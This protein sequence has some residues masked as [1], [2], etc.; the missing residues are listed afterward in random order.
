MFAMPRPRSAIPF[1][2]AA[3]VALGA[4]V[5]GSAP[6]GR[7][8]GAVLAAPVPAMEAEEAIALIEGE[9]GALRFDVAEDATRFAWAGEPE[10]VDGMPAG[11]TP[12]ATQGYLY[13]EGTLTESSGVNP[14]GSPEFPDKVLGQWSCWGWYL[15]GAAGAGA[16]PWLTTHVFN[17][18]GAW[19][20]AT[21]VSEGYGID[22]LGVPL[23][24]AI[25]GGTGPYAEARG[26]QLETGLGFNATEGMNFRYELQIAGD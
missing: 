23:A 25:T 5:L 12:Y 10:L 16:A 6:P 21:V 20:E 13:P 9:D 22:D 14:D 11:R 4:V 26:V 8:D 18:G 24:R 3:V 17:F 19:G 1:A 2:L 7:I 15:G